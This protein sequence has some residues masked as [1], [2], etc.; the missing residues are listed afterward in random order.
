METSYDRY[1]RQTILPEMGM[2][3][4]QKLLQSKVLVVGAGGLGCPVLQYLAA[5]GVGTIGIID[6][7]VVSL[8]NL[9]RQV[10]YNMA[11]LGLSKAICAA[12]KLRAG[13]PDIQ[14]NVY[15]KRLT[16][17]NALD[18]IGAYD[19]IVDGTDSFSS[20]YMINDACVLL[21]KPLV[22]GA[23][24]Q[25]E[26]QVAVFN[27]AREGGLRTANYRDVFPLPP[28]AGAVLNCAEAGVLGVL[29][30]IIG[31]L[32]ATEVIK[33][34]TGIGQPLLDR[35]LT[36]NALNNQLFEIAIAPA[37]ATRFLIP[38]DFAAFRNMD[39]DWTC[40]A[41]NIIEITDNEFQVLLQEPSVMI[42][43][44]REKGELPF[45]TDFPHLHLPLTQLQQGVPEIEGATIVTF[46][47]SG[48][49][50]K[51]AAALLFQEFRTSKKIY[52]LKDGIRSL[53]KGFQ[54]LE[55]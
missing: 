21:G 23:I 33:L 44:V 37:E 47:Q 11:D 5:A 32:Q 45:I 10:L 54:S 13:N 35:M 51:Q 6:D 18:I 1:Q 31:T 3:G 39:Y 30:G 22:Y 9:H 43:D 40:M 34:I 26:G 20:R 41:Q 19:I 46:C 53:S 36:Y 55:S 17:Q 2:E 16:N 7:D 8:S 25:F 4:Q 49:R 48:K 24:S 38:N 50:S 42:I 14:I 15:N 28:A 52:S 29:P 12:A 27:V